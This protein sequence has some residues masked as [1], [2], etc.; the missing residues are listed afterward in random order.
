MF[1]KIVYCGSI[2]YNTVVIIHKTLNNY[3]L[4]R[5]NKEYGH[6]LYF[7]GA[8]KPP[9]RWRRCPDLAGCAAVGV[10]PDPSGRLWLCRIF[11]RAGCPGWPA[12][13]RTGSPGALW[14]VSL[15]PVFM[16]HGYAF[17]SVARA[18]LATVCA[19]TYYYMRARLFLGY[20][21]Y[22]II[23]LSSSTNDGGI[24]CAV[25]TNRKNMRKN[26]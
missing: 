26:D 6:C 19:R 18:V 14:R 3:S 21:L 13:R 2:V 12:L 10:A 4:Y 16:G 5:N 15:R 22:I 24:L 7:Y 20:I 9:K 25:L 1:T 11:A 8:R 23:P 17:R